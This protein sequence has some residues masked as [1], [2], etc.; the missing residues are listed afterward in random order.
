MEYG[1]KTNV[2][3]FTYLKYKKDEMS[4][5]KVSTLM[6]GWSMEW[7]EDML[8]Y[9]IL[10]GDI[11]EDERNG[12]NVAVINAFMCATLLDGDFQHSVQVAAGELQERLNEGVKS[13]SEEEDAEIL[14]QLR[15]EHEMY[16]ELGKE[17]GW[18]EAPT[19]EIK[20]AADK[21]A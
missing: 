10:D 5:I 19:G 21:L 13:V 16:E 15:T 18:S 3:G 8:M 1:K 2:G 6:G 17:Q 4:F 12:L 20:T 7:R 14:K 9:H 11:A